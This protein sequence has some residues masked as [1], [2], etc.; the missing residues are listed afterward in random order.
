MPPS[1][2][3]SPLITILAG[4]EEKLLHAHANVLSESETFKLMIEGGWKEAKES[5]IKLR[6][7]DEDTISRI[8]DFLYTSDY[9]TPFPS[10]PTSSI[11]VG[12]DAVAKILTA[13]S[14]DEVV[15]LNT[16]NVSK[17]MPIQIGA[18]T[19]NLDDIKHEATSLARKE[20]EFLTFI[21]WAQKHNNE[22]ST[23]NHGESLMAHAKVYALADYLLLRNL[24]L[25]AAKRLRASVL[26]IGAFQ[27]GS[28]AVNDIAMVAKYIYTN[29]NDYKDGKP[30]EEEPLRK[31]ISGVIA[32]NYKNFVG[33]GAD[34]VFREGGDLAT[35]VFHKMRAQSAVPEKGDM[36]PFNKAMRR[37]SK[38]E[39]M[40][41]DRKVAK[42]ARVTS[43]G[44]SR[45]P[46]A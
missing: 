25:L 16:T 37:V 19:G 28:P 13:I 7:W 18:P 20:T 3:A 12:E 46:E 2:F 36:S 9:K 42:K 1:V 21:A 4:E 22:A 5:R 23:L 40:S 43:S 41:S 39:A 14:V 24:K 27:P 44:K 32:T 45:R 31:F 38:D 17:S 10:R 26:F 35:D 6:E 8:L 29:T 15:T 34:Q 33:E 11:Q 30:E